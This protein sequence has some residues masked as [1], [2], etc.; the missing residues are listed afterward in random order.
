M[1][2]K[3]RCSVKFEISGIDSLVGLPVIGDREQRL[4]AIKDTVEHRDYGKLEDFNFE[5]VDSDIDRENGT[6]TVTVAVTGYRTE[7]SGG[8][9]M[10]EGKQCAFAQ[11]ACMNYGCL[12]LRIIKWKSTSLIK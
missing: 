10:E 5:I 3:H 4:Q 11:A 12:D 1:V 2:V 9:T 7:E 8:D 6:E